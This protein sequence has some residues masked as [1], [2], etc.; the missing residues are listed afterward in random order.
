MAERSKAPVSRFVIKDAVLASI[1]EVT[2]GETR[3]SS[4]L[5]L[6]ISIFFFLLLFFLSEAVM[7]VCKYY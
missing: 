3:T 1:N 4:N 7:Y 6:V 2:G 5:V